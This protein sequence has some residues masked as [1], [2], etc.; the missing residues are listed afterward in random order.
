MLLL[1][2]GFVNGYELKRINEGKLSRPFR[3]TNSYV[4]FV[5]IVRYFMGFRQLEGFTIALHRLIP[6]LPPIDYSWRR[7]LRLDL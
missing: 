3:L 1:E 6:R 5:G 2:L 7:V 4:K